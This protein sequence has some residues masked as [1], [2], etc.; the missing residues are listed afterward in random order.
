MK[1]QEWPA[2][3]YAIGS[4]IQASVSDIYL[5]GLNIKPTDCVL[6]IGC[7]DGAYTKK[8]LDKV[9]KGSVLGIDASAN[10]LDL[11]ADVKKDYPNFSLQKADV[12]SMAFK[13][14]FD[15][16]VSFWC[17]QWAQ[18]IHKAFANI[19]HSLKPGGTLFALF[20]AGDDPYI[21][22]YYALKQS[23]TF[24]SLSEFK[25]PVDY[26]R[27]DNL[28]EQLADLPFK[29]LQVK[30]CQQS[31]ILP[32]LEVFRK[33]VNGIAFYQGQISDHEIKDINE[34]LVHYFDDECQKKYHGEYQFNFTNY[35]IIGTK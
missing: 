30:L 32:S 2:E 5:S 6:D 22:G 11:A 3:D 18:D 34:A 25:P 35:L 8:I 31:I 24:K 28:A 9:P 14:K 1:T 19:F 4:F 12:L 33:F 10:M 17:L 20:P 15:Y 13:E 7:G 27:M 29:H 21:M 26:S 23:G 16:I